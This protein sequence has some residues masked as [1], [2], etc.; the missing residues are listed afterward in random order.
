GRSVALGLLWIVVMMTLSLLALFPAGLLVA[1]IVIGVITHEVPSLA[2][3]I[4]LI[5]IGLPLY[6]VVSGWFS[7]FSNAY[8]VLGYRWARPWAP[9]APGMVAGESATPMAM[10]P[11][12]PVH[13]TAPESGPAPA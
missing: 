7:T 4:P 2:E 11:E 5:L 10:H 12:V 1:P 6:I 13:P 3:I 9:P 8:W